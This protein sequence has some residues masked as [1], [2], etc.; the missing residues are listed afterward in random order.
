MTL[1]NVF[2]KRSVK[3]TQATLSEI[4]VHNVNNGVEKKKNLGTFEMHFAQK[5]KNSNL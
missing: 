4:M 3:Q 2:F 1:F 5:F